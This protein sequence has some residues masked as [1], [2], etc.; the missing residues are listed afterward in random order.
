MILAVTLAASVGGPFA[1]A[2]QPGPGGMGPPS[3]ELRAKFDAV[4][5]QAKTS[6]YA[7]LSPDHRAR[8]QAI[9]ARVTSGA[10]PPRDGAAQID[11]LV[12]PDEAKAVLAVAA[13]ERAQIRAAFGDSAPPPP[14]PPGNGGPP[15][16]PRPPGGGAPPPDPPA[17]P[18]DGAPPNGGP[19]PD[20]AP[21]H[22]GGGPGG[23]RAQTAGAFL[24]RVSVTPEQMR[25]L[26]AAN[27]PPPAP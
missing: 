14:P 10:V 12:S 4:D 27:R 15:P 7:A 9:V 21:P 1:A 19:P 5:A 17:P 26:R 20:G 8:V 13:A 6:A 23:R 25:A 11:A 18:D 3:P 22:G 2:A 24:L 16:G